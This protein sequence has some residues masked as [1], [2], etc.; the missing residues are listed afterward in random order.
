ME[1][2]FALWLKAEPL[3]KGVGLRLETWR[4]RLASTFMPGLASKPAPSGDWPALSARE[5]KHVP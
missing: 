1:R 2:Q 3:I 4:F 5:P